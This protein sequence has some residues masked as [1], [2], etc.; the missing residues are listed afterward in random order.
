MSKIVG[1]TGGIGSGKSVIAKV[2]E[3]L[4][5]P[6]FDSDK[7]G[8]LA[9]SFSDVKEKVVNLLGSEAYAN[10][11]VDKKYISAK[12][13][14]DPVLLSQLN[15]IIHPH[16]AEQFSVWC[17]MQQSEVLIK[18]S[19]I[20]FETGLYKKLH[21]TVLVVAP[22]ELRIRRVMKREQVSAAAVEERMRMQWRDIDKI[23]LATHVIVNN[24]EEMVI[25][26]VISVYQSL[27]S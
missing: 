11:E 8:I 7:A 17:A 25:P 27:I 1:L 13:F 12:V 22:K 15:A 10:G 2:F 23:K 14:S 18:E 21:S 3:T 16:V 20:L 5:V 26:Q 9:Y 4:G 6:V 19:A 24:E